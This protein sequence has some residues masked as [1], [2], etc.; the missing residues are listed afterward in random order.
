MAFLGGTTQSP[1]VEGLLVGVRGQSPCGSLW[2]WLC[3][4][5]LYIGQAY[6]SCGDCIKLIPR[7]PAMFFMVLEDFRS[8]L[9]MCSIQGRV[10]C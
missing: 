3:C 4:P 2:K 10:E 1:L 6:Y 9:S 8:T 7:K 5:Y